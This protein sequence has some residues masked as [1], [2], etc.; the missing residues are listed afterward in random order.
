WSHT[1]VGPQWKPS[2]V[3]QD[4]MTATKFELSQNFPNPFN[5]ST[6]I[7][8]SVPV[9]GMV[10]LKIYDVLGREVMTVV[11][12]HQ[13]EGAYTVSLDASTLSS[14]MYVYK[15]ESGALS[16]SKKMMLLK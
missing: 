1:W 16:V 4:A 2:S 7:R 5:P 8:Y 13:S 10:S 6:S 14:G 9:S 12:Q 3:R 15:L 11:N